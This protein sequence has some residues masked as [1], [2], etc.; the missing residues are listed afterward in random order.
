MFRATKLFVA[1][2]AAAVVLLPGIAQA[3]GQA[4]GSVSGSPRLWRSAGQRIR[5]EAVAA[6]KGSA[7]VGGVAQIRIEV[8]PLASPAT[9][10]QSTDEPLVGAAAPATIDVVVSDETGA[11][12]PEGAVRDMPAMRGGVRNQGQAG[13]RVVVDLVD[14][15][16]GIARLR[17]SARRVVVQIVTDGSAQSV[18][19]QLPTAP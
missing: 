18:S 3:Q 17:P 11:S 6:P 2:L 10:V 9:A 1:S 8:T 12:L 13:R 5:A 7:A 15:L 19:Y 4:H 14:P 16:T